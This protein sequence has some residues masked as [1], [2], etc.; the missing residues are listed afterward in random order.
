[1]ISGAHRVRIC[2]G[3]RV[4][5]SVR[6]DRMHDVLGDEIAIHRIRD[7]STAHNKV[8]RSSGERHGLDLHRHL[9]ENK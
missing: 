6:E 9:Q 2:V 7:L 4:N 8:N 1:M 3:D 5:V